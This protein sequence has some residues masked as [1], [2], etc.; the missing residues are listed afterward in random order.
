MLSC[1][2]GETLKNLPFWQSCLPYRVLYQYELPHRVLFNQV[3]QI[4]IMYLIQ[5]SLEPFAMYFSTT[6]VAETTKNGKKVLGYN[7]THI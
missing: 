4:L 6:I 5:F 1:L 3:H 7:Y 2:Q